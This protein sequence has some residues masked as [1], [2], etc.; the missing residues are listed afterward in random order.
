MTSREFTESLAFE[1]LEPD[2]AVMTMQLV[3]QLLT[4]YANVHRDTRSKPVP[5]TVDDF[6]PNPYGPS[7]A[8]RQAAHVAV[9]ASFE[10]HRKGMVD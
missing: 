4:L 7:K 6:L 10:R 5:F 9:M 2:P 3:G 1:H 8:E